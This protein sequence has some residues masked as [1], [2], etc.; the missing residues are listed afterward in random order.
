MIETHLIKTFFDAKTQHAQYLAR[1][2]D[3]TR[4]SSLYTSVNA[5]ED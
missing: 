3:N 2:Y 1:I 5:A 4:F